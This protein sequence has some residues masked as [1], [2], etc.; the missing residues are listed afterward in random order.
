MRLNIATALLVTLLVTL[1]I[2]GADLVTP[3]SQCPGPDYFAFVIS[4]KIDPALKSLIYK[5]G[6]EKAQRSFVVVAVE[7]TRPTHENEIRKYLRFPKDI[8]MGKRTF[9]LN[10]IFAFTNDAHVVETLT[11]LASMNVVHKITLNY[12]T[13][14]TNSKLDIT[15]SKFPSSEDVFES[16]EFK[17]S[18]KVTVQF[19]TN[20]LSQKE[21]REAANEAIKACSRKLQLK[22][23]EIDPAVIL[24]ST[25][26]TVSTYR[27]DGSIFTR[28]SSISF[29]VSFTLPGVGE[30]TLRVAV[31][32]NSI[33]GNFDHPMV[34]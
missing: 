22:K 5:E 10:P 3:V 27:D 33:T 1:P 8:R 32:R 25:D 4:S 7:F 12:A 19:P 14:N 18:P 20:Y 29:K 31:G 28:G 13:D 16:H 11:D 17:N 26:L 2:Q 34:E 30:R 15:A 21:I 23:L 9:D 6:Q 24:V